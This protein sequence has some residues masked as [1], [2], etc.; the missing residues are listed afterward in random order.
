MKRALAWSARAG[1]TRPQDVA[2]PGRSRADVGMGVVP[3]DPP[4]LEHAF[5][6]AVVAGPPDVIHHLLAASL[7]DRLPDPFAEGLQ[8]LVPA[9]P[10]PFALSALANAFE[11]IED[12]V[13]IVDLIDHGRPLGTQPASASGMG[14]IALELLDP[15]GF[16]VDVG[17]Q[18]AGRLAVEA[19]GGDQLVMPQLMPRPGLGVVFRTVIPLVDRR[20][21]GQMTIGARK[22]FMVRPSRIKRGGRPSSA[23]PCRV[24]CSAHLGRPS[25]STTHR[26]AAL[27]AP[28][29]GRSDQSRMSPAD[30]QEHDREQDAEHDGAAPEHPAERPPRNQA[31]RVVAVSVA[32]GISSPVASVN[33]CRA[34]PPVKAP[35]ATRIADGVSPNNGATSASKAALASQP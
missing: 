15:A 34:S 28:A 31:G 32:W 10:L 14:G 24:N 16:L 35:A 30:G 13:G 27:P 22:S 29:P 23:T 9:D 25:R 20:I 18:P 4:A 26:P 3:V 21:G 17:Q 12:P 33:R 7:D 11:R 8:H 1:R 6:V 5:H 19:D 2:E